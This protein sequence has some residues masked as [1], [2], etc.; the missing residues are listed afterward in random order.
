[1]TLK[2]VH[3]AVKSLRYAISKPRIVEG[4]RFREEEA[5]EKDFLCISE[6]PNVSGFY[7]AQ[8]AVRRLEKRQKNSNRYGRSKDGGRRQG[9][10]SGRKSAKLQK[11]SRK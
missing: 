3:F 5:E 1:M 7:S 4:K 9:M 2:R 8:V 6:A 10:R 11:S